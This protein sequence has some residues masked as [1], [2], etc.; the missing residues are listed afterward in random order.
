MAPAINLATTAATD[1]E[2]MYEGHRRGK[3]LFGKE[4]V[5]HFDGIERTEL[6]RPTEAMRESNTRHRGIPKRNWKGE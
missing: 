2:E 4:A 1:L 6:R 3:A 5:K